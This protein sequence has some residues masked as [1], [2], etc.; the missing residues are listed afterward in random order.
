MSLGYLQKSWDRATTALRVDPPVSCSE[1]A[2]K[3]W[4]LSNETSPQPGR[5]KATPYQTGLLDILAHD[6]I[7]TIVVQ[8]SARVGY[9]VCTIITAM[10]LHIQKKRNCIIYNPNEELASETMQSRI[11][12]A[13]RDVPLLEKLTTG[14]GT[15]KVAKSLNLNNGTVFRSLGGATPNSY[16]GKDADGIFIDE[17][18]AIPTNLGEG[19]PISLARMRSMTSPRPK[20]IIGSTPLISGESL[21]ESNMADA[22]LKIKFF[23]KC[24]SCESRA[25]LEWGGVD[26]PTGIRYDSG[27]PETASWICPSCGS[28]H[29][30]RYQ[31]AMV[32]SGRWQTE[33]GTYWDDGRFIKDDVVVP[34][35]KSVGITIWSAYN[36]RQSW[37]EICRVHHL[38][39]NDQE[40]LQA[41]T[42]TWIGEYY[43]REV[44]T[45]EPSPL[46]QRRE[47]YSGVPDDVICITVGAD[48]QKDRIEAHYIGWG[49]N[50]ECWSLSYRT[51]VGDPE[52]EHVWEDFHMDLERGI[53]LDETGEQS[54]PVIQ[55]LVDS[56]YQTMKVYGQVRAYGE[57]IMMACKGMSTHGAPLVA[58]P[59]KRDRDHRIRLVRIGTENGKDMIYSRLS[60]E[61]PGAGYLHFPR[62]EEHNFEFFRQLCSEEKVKAKRGGR[63]VYTYEQKKGLSNEVLD[64]TVYALAA[65]KM[66]EKKGRARSRV[67][68]EG[69]GRIKSRSKRKNDPNNVPRM[70]R[71]PKNFLDL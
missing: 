70:K 48:I 7:P 17:L 38:A 22:E 40:K 26:A 25:S 43:E 31:R 20:L 60:L 12:P 69:G 19:D 32:Q 44:V 3:F 49:A 16:R 46:Y 57:R 21:V 14:F 50:E 64:T 10:Y 13:I 27:K 28:L 5:F 68:I 51:Y 62:D 11:F 58:V 63:Q 36:V 67:I 24:P 61:S 23:I 45:V 41:H 39:G 29:E 15:R 1:W 34:M 6:Q 52:Q 56:G 8:K 59:K 65:Y 54:I 55:A 4:Y 37:G 71:K 35:P 30:Y 47:E 66:A 33:D 42:N 18:D 9:T 2:A 53:D